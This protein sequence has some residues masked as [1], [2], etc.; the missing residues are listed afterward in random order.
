MTR[1]G[2]FF[3]LRG[4]MSRFITNPDLTGELMRRVTSRL[5]TGLVAGIV[6]VTTAAGLA[7]L[8]IP[9]RADAS[10]SFSRLSGSDRFATAGAID[11]AA[12]PS[13][14]PSATT[15]LAD[16]LPAHAPDAL[17]AAGLEGVDGIGLLLTDN[18]DTVPASTLSALTANKVH[19]ISVLGGTSSVSSAQVTQLK[20]DGYTVVTPFQGSTRYQ[21]M[22]M[23]D[24]SIK[25]SQVGTDSSGNP[26]AILASGDPAHFVDALSAG[27]L[28]YAKKFPII[29]TN[30]TTTGLQPEAQQV[31]TALGIKDL[32]V[33]G[34]TSSIPASQYSPA[35]TGVTQVEVEFGADRSATSKTLADYAISQTWLKN[36]HVDLAR[37]DDGSDALAGSAFGGV[38]GF[39]TVITDSPTSDGSA[40]TF[41]SEHAS[42][43][44]GTSYI[45]GGTSAVP[46]TQVSDVQ[47]AAGSS[48]PATS[49]AISPSS[50][51]EVNSVSTTSFTQGGLSYTYKNS[52]TYQV[53]TSGGTGA[54][55][56]ASSYAVFQ[57]A[58]SQGDIVTGT[59]STTAASTF[60]LNDQSPNPPSSSAKATPNTTS[61]GVTVTWS[62]PSTAIGDG[63]TAYDIYRAPAGPPASTGL[64]YTC[65]A[66]YTNAPGT[67][68][69][70]PPQSANGYTLLT[71]VNYG[72]GTNGSYTYQ[73]TTATP[74]SGSTANEY[75]Y[76]ISSVDVA[77]SGNQI[78]SAQPLGANP[79]QAAD[80]GPVG[81]TTVTAP[82]ITGVAGA[83]HTITITYN[84]P[85]NSTTVAGNGSDFVVTGATFTPSTL[86]TKHAFVP[87][88][89]SGNTVILDLDYG[90]V[91][92]GF[93]VTQ[94]SGGD[95]NT[96]CANGSTSNCA[97]SGG[98]PVT[99]TSSAA[100]SA[101]TITGVSASF[102]GQSVT[103]TYSEAIDCATVD[104]SGDQYIVTIGG[105][106]EAPSGAKCPSSGST[107]PTT[108]STVVLS[109]S[110][111]LI[112]PSSPIT[113]SYN[114][115]STANSKTAS[116]DG[117]V[118]STTGG[119]EPLPDP[120]SGT[121]SGSTGT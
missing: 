51:Q 31:I 75:C 79:L 44:T 121:V 98:T 53:T 68:P 37:G 120:N 29:L 76:A 81:P 24:D 32:I 119:G 99:T 55:C 48:K 49:G 100:G 88:T 15:F 18:S 35:P 39:P 87:S 61:G 80:P 72:S 42:T 106:N 66:A 111:T 50:G 25:P 23:L 10:V 27:A 71:S 97:A 95:G 109:F 73:D 13:G 33:V 85:I 69:Q 62:D 26:T 19:Q 38:N 115:L 20:N 59:Y 5:R 17:A 12:Y 3:R 67:S 16:G 43:L 34:G 2:S 60:C 54:S 117:I 91:A 93:T 114:P 70:A 7:A 105:T 83:G 103:V 63:V 28:A 22:Q 58:L 56:T 78:G 45:F 65:Q 82:A 11:Q 30:S 77:A 89:G 118:C 47:N 57:A 9:A 113:V 46:D 21:T 64:P 90:T 74:G 52:D 94:Q 1:E 4:F 8:T 102:T 107:T 36:T 40:P 14:A 92:S 96:V 104:T 110:S 108:S 116:A 86:T 41:A 84:E 6:G 101:P 112:A